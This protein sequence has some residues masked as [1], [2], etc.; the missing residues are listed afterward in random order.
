MLVIRQT[1]SKTQLMTFSTSFVCQRKDPLKQYKKRLQE[2]K[3]DR[4][5]NA[6]P[7]KT[8]VGMR[9]QLKN[10]DLPDPEDPVFQIYDH[11]IDITKNLESIVSQSE[12]EQRKIVEN[13]P[14]EE[15]ID[16]DEIRRGIIKKKYF[17]DPKEP[18]VLFTTIF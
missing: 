6:D 10:M 14:R 16:K 7:F 9:H 12:I 15:Y 17:P 4:I 3:L 2:K 13:M 8:N 1:V 18:Q 5:Q 11:S